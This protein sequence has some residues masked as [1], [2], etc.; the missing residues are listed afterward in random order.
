MWRFIGLLARRGL[1]WLSL[2]LS[3]FSCFLFGFRPGFPYKRGQFAQVFNPVFLIN[4]I[5]LLAFGHFEQYI[6]VEDSS[7]GEL[8]KKFPT[9]IVTRQVSRGRLGFIKVSDTSKNNN[10][11]KRR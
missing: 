7:L 9:L 11:D 3:S 5:T 2:F 4:W 8:L 10:N 6:Q 1:S